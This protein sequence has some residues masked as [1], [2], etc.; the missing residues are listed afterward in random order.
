MRQ[1]RASRT[2]SGD[3]QLIPL[4]FILLALFKLLASYP[5]HEAQSVECGE[6]FV[7][8]GSDPGRSGDGCWHACTLNLQ[9]LA[10]TS[11]LDIISPVAGLRMYNNI[12][13]A[14]CEVEKQMLSPKQYQ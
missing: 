14:N 2:I 11:A 5:E 13:F 9:L 6:T 4:L 3:K 7:R 1:N 8:P 10:N 12:G